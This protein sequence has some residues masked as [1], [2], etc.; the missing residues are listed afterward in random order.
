[1]HLLL[2]LALFAQVPDG[3]P[4]ARTINAAQRD[5]IF[6]EQLINAAR[7]ESN[8]AAERAAQ[9]QAMNNGEKQFVERFNKFT[10]LLKQFADHYN[11]RHAID[12]KELQAVKK[13]WH[14]IEKGDNSFRDTGT[15]GTQ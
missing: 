10:R 3:D 9:R 11:T 5:E 12:I 14:D 4:N 2:L 15:H 6:R 13:A 1:M 7:T 8:K